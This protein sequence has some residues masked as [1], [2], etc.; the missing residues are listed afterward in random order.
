MNFRSSDKLATDIPNP[1]KETLS[2][3]LIARFIRFLSRSSGP[4]KK[5]SVTKTKGFQGRNSINLQKIPIH[6]TAK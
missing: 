3:H 4:F 2:N 1:R 6:G 5:H